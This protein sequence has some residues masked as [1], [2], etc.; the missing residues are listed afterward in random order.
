MEPIEPLVEPLGLSIKTTAAIT[1][2]SEWQV[3]EK[4]RTGTYQA[5]K[6]G[7]RTIVIYQSVKAAF[8]ALPDWTAAKLTQPQQVQEQAHVA[9]AAARAHRRAANRSTKELRT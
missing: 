9:A 5:K 2:E 3:K 1:G 6:S 8:D 7:R 4:L